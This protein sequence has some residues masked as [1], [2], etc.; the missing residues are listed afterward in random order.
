M[1][2][3]R[4]ALLAVDNTFA[5]PYNQQPLDLGA[6]IVVHSSTKY[7]NGH[8]DVIGGIAIT[9]DAKIAEDLHYMQKA[10]GA[11]NGKFSEVMSDPAILA[12]LD[13]LLADVGF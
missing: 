2:H 13:K 4:E 7:L 8:S 9:N 6:D 1:V 5:S 10:A 12:E 3:K 11:P